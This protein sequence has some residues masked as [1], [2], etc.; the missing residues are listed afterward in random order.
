MRLPA[1]LVAVAQEH[2]AEVRGEGDREEHED[3]GSGQAQ[4]VVALRK[5]ERA[6]E[7]SFE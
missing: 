5:M 4:T 7:G 3:R 1:L 6:N 2:R